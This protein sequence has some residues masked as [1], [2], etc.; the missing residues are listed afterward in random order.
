MTTAIERATERD[1][2]R[3]VTHGT[4][5]IERTY[6]ASAR[7]VFD[8]WSSRD[9][10]LEWFAQGIDFLRSV[11]EYSLD[12]RVGGAEHLVGVTARSRL[13]FEYDATHADILDEQRIVAFY[14]VRI[15]GRRI[16]ASVLTVEFEPAAG[17]GDLVG[18]RVILTEQGAFLDGLDTNEERIVGATSNLDSLERYLTQ[19]S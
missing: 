11:D 4:F 6:A 3:T 13:R 10:K 18:T 8:A 12:F 7:T 17:A 19:R 5:T 9:A 14:D 16:S 1:S 2:L 15:D